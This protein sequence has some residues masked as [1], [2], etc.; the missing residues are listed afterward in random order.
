MKPDEQIFRC[1]CGEPVCLIVDKL[2]F[3]SDDL[4]SVLSVYVQENQYS[5]WYKLKHL[6][7]NH[8]GWD[9]ILGFDD[10]KRLHKALGKWIKEIDSDLKKSAQQKGDKK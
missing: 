7:K 4:S 8:F 2:Y 1:D 3:P 5:F 9:F 6:F 10:A